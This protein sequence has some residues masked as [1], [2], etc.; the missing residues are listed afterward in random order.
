MNKCLDCG[1]DCTGKRCKKC[2]TKSISK[3]FDFGNW[4]FDTATELNNTIKYMFQ[5]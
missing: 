1:N 5:S 2:F 3:S 4:H